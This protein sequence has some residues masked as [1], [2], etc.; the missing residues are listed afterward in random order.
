MRGQNAYPTLPPSLS[1]RAAPLRDDNSVNRGLAAR[2]CYYC[3]ATRAEAAFPGNYKPRGRR[4]RC[5]SCIADP[6]WEAKA[7][8]RA[9]RAELAALLAAG[10]F[11]HPK[12]A[13]ALPL[14][15]AADGQSG[16]QPPDSPERD[17]SHGLD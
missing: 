12:P 17:P 13:H 16:G 9:R 3:G 8:V 2:R 5:A 4:D 11:R 1:T 15:A 6:L 14:F 7:R 10:G